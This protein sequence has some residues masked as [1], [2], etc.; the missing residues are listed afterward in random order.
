MV[1]KTKEGKEFVEGEVVNSSI[2][3]LVE[4]VGVRKRFKRLHLA[5]ANYDAIFRIGWSL[6]VQRVGEED[7]AFC[8]DGH[9]IVF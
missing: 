5:D 2:L 7:K 9:L 4:K 6:E 1:I 8:Q 3:A